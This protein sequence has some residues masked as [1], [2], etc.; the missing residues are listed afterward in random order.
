MHAG[1]NR[2]IVETK[3]TLNF[4]AA[5]RRHEL[6]YTAHDDVEVRVPT[7]LVPRRTNGLTY[8]DYDRFAFINSS[9]LALVGGYDETLPQYGADYDLN[10][11]FALSSFPFTDLRL[12]R[13]VKHIGNRYRNTHA[14][15]QRGPDV[16]GFN[17]AS[18]PMYVRKWGVSSEP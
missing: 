1:L 8:I 14:S 7:N 18:S 3:N 16:Y 5:C 6:Y 10:R 4:C 2:L 17:G 15:L 13:F 9:A 11:R 12:E